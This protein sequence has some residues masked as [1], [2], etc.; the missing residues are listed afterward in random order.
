MKR[1]VLT[2]MLAT[3]FMPAFAAAQEEA[4]EDIE[5]QMEMQR[6]ELELQQQEF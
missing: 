5:F 1:Y 2:M 3:I 6:R 4:P